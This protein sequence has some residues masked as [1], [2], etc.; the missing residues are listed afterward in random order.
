MPRQSP[1][2]L[3]LRT[4]A[5]LLAERNSSLEITARL[6]TASV[7]PDKVWVFTPAFHSLINLSAL[8]VTIIPT[9]VEKFLV[10][11]VMVGF[12]YLWKHGHSPDSKGV[13][14]QSHRDFSV[15]PGFGSFIP[16]AG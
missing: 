15:A 13:T 4:V 10:V 1:V 16:A 5:S 6:L 8:A 9:W 14:G 7:C 11:F 3:H 12:N 2:L